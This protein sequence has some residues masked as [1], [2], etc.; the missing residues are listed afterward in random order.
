MRP[1]PGVKQVS[2]LLRLLAASSSPTQAITV[3]ERGREGNA[4]GAVPGGGRAEGD[5]G[6]PLGMAASVRRPE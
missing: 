3:H 5:G 4:L 1:C 2:G 6:G